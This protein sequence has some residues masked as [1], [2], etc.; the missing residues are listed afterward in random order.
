[1]SGCSVHDPANYTQ[2]TIYAFSDTHAY[3][4]HSYENSL[5]LVDTTRMLCVDKSGNVRWSIDFPTASPLIKVAGRYILIAD[6]SGNHAALISRGNIIKS[7]ELDGIIATTSLNKNG[8][9]S[10]STN[11]EG[12]KSILTAYNPLGDLYYQWKTS[13]NFIIDSHVSKNGKKIACSLLSTK[14]GEVV[15][16]V[17][18]ID[19]D[20]AETIKEFQYDN[21]IFSDVEILSNGSLL[22]IGDTMTLAIPSSYNNVIFIDYRGKILQDYAYTSSGRLALAFENSR[23]ATT[24]EVYSKSLKMTGSTD[25]P[26]NISGMEIARGRVVLFDT[27]KINLYSYKGRAKVLSNLTGSFS[28]GTSS[29]SH[30]SFFVVGANSVRLITLR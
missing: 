11:A 23:N 5:L 17:S 19:A 10:I 2:K 16:I 1:M 14:N 26:F 6:S 29:G 4:C 20:K 30:N 8:F 21:A 25:V 22:A 13:E 24:L 15:G 9:F 18:V 27:H 28:W 12:Y 3:N 7:L